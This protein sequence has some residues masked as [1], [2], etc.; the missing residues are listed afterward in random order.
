MQEIVTLDSGG[1]LGFVGFLLADL[2]ADQ[3]IRE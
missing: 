2:A 3:P 1:P